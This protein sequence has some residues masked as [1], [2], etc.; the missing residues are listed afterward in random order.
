M[1]PDLEQ[2]SSGLADAF[3]AVAD[4]ERLRIELD[5]A[6]AELAAE[7]DLTRQLRAAIAL[8]PFSPAYVALS[9]LEQVPAPRRASRRAS[10]RSS[11]TRTPPQGIPVQRRSLD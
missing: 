2:L 5:Q 10:Q 4:R 11:V 9:R 8:M 6:R 7:R 1:S 3:A